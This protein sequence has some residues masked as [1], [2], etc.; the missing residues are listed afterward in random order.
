VVCGA[1]GVV[2]SV[3]AFG[4]TIET[5][6]LGLA[7]EETIVAG[8]VWQ[9]D[10]ALRVEIGAFGH[11]FDYTKLI[12]D[13]FGG[14][15]SKDYLARGVD[16]GALFG[17]EL[18]RQ[19]RELG[20]VTG[21]GGWKVTGIVEDLYLKN[22]EV[23]FGPLLFFGHVDLAL[24]VTSPAGEVTTVR[25]RMHPTTGR[26]NA[27]FGAKDE[28]MEAI[29]QVII[30]SAQDAIARLNRQFFRQP[31]NGRAADKI[32]DVRRAGREP[33]ENDLRWLGLSGAPEAVEPLLAV[34][35]GAANETTRAEAIEALGLLGAKDA[36]AELRKS[37]AR[38]KDED[39]RYA[40]LAVTPELDP[41][42]GLAWVTANGPKDK[43]KEC[44]H[45]ALRLMGRTR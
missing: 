38:E 39:V 13:D 18:G 9:A 8:T 6:D 5:L 19:A 1:L 41:E 17:E 27:G 24:E 33:D 34:A 45:L 4:G 30:E 7:R 37:F 23:S 43:K 44:Q 40:L 20:L 28:N 36:V 22:R 32:A 14:S 15:G 26:F 31:A 3:A 29:A 16:V 2:G 12:V 10:P 42:N 25:Y 11:R 21:S 35:R